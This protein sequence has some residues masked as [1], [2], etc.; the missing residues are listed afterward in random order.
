MV[1]LMQN[2]SKTDTR[3]SWSCFHSMTLAKVSWSKKP[4]MWNLATV[5]AWS[6]LIHVTLWRNDGF[7]HS[8]CPFSKSNA[9][10]ENFIRTKFILHNFFF[11]WVYFQ[12]EKPRASSIY[13]WKGRSLIFS[14][15]LLLVM[16]FHNFFWKMLLFSTNFLNNKICGI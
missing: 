2:E 8:F 7:F 6:N 16:V 15:Q 9:F 14:L 4:W 12:A 3:K 10:G 13:I 1:S 11:E 5:P